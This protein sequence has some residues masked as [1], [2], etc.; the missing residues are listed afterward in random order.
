MVASVKVNTESLEY[1]AEIV[2]KRPDLILLT[3]D[4]YGTFADDFVSLFALCPKNTILV[5]SYS[6]Y[7]GATGW[8]LGTIAMHHDNVIDALIADSRTVA[9]NHT[10]GLSTPQQVQSDVLIRRAGWVEETIMGQH[11]VCHLFLVYQG[12]TQWMA[13]GAGAA[14]RQV[15]LVASRGPLAE[16]G[17]RDPR[18]LE[19]VVGRKRRLQTIP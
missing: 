13:E 6:R 19:R 10:A 15:S 3:D 7:F 14:A 17:E 1:I 12:L 18:W 9:L 16:M 4:V 11:R 8:R 5:Y 2:K